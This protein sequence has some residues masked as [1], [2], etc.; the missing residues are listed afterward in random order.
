MDGHGRA[1]VDLGQ[2]KAGQYH[3]QVIA[4]VPSIEGGVVTGDMFVSVVPD[5]DVI[6]SEENAQGFTVLATPALPTFEELW[7]GAA[8]VNIF[9]PKGWQ[10]KA[11][12]AF[13]SDPAGLSSPI[14]VHSLR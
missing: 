8:R 5:D 14:F 9:G 4:Q 3:L 13:Y 1:F 11:Q 7:A 6:L 10:L 12:L 2:L